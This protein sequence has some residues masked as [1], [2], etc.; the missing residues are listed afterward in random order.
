LRE[1][2]TII[3]ENIPIRVSQSGRKSIFDT[4]FD[5]TDFLHENAENV[6]E[7]LFSLISLH[8]NTVSYETNRAMR[9]IAVLSALVVI[10]TVVGGMLGMNLF[11]IPYRV[12]LWQIVTLT[13]IAMIAVGWIFY[14]LGWL[15]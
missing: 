3:A 6:R 13:A 1:V 7:S 2:A 9:L 11:D 12:H 15:R 10:P 5:E 8:I 14:K 4:L